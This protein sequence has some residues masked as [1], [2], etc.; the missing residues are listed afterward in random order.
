MHVC[1]HECASPNETVATH[2]NSNHF[3]NHEVMLH[4]PEWT[5]ETS[6]V[7]EVHV[8]SVC[9]GNVYIVYSSC[10]K[11]SVFPPQEYCQEP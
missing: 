7:L 8:C 5:L 1:G 2:I 9:V 6:N 11:E 10:P 4:M 3:K